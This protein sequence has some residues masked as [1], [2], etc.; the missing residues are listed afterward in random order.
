MTYNTHEL[1][2]QLAVKFEMKI[3][4]SPGEEEVGEHELQVHL[5]E[6]ALEPPQPHPVHDNRLHSNTQQP[7]NTINHPFPKLVSST[8]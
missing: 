6:L 1:M 7:R 4:D 2:Q 8:H 5:E 3:S